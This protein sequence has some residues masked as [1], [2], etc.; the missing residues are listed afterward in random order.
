MQNK[1][2]I[3][4]VALLSYTYKVY[5]CFSECDMLCI[6]LFSPG[7]AKTCFCMT[8]AFLG[9]IFKMANRNNS[10]KLEDSDPA[11]INFNSYK[12]NSD[13]YSKFTIIDIGIIN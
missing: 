1:Q 10:K 7:R 13:S 2:N 11:I 5:T 9:F 4:I 3:Y 8:L 6:H 12:F